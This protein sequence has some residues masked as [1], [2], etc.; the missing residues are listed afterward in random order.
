[1]PH[2]PSSSAAST[3]LGS[4]PRE[5]EGVTDASSSVDRE[6]ALRSFVAEVATTL[7]VHEATAGRLIADAARLA[8]GF[9]DTLDALADGSLTIAHVR[10]LL[11]VATTLPTERTA[12]FEAL[13]LERAARETP[14]AFSRRIRRLRERLH[15]EPPV[16][17]HQRAREDRRVCLDPAE[18]GMAWLGLYLEAERG[19][20]IMARLDALADAGPAAGADAGCDDTR[21]P[22]SRAQLTLDVAADLLLGQGAGDVESPLGVVTPRVY[23]TVPV[24]TLLGHAD[25]PAD[26]DG[27][28]PIDARPLADSARMHRRSGGS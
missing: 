10:S 18:D 8:D 19:V 6:F 22:R 9:T 21:D 2:R 12:E 7:V 5:V 27:Y 13:A 16:A 26:L 11:E 25:E 28:G 15:P 20:A 23:V 3:Q 24:L 4:S 1:M 14:S 17:R